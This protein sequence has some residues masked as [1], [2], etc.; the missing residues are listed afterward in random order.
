MISRDD[1]LWFIDQALNGMI[2]IVEDLGDDLAN[3][4]PDIPGANSPYVILAHCLGV[5][6]YWGGHAIA[7]REI[8]RDHQAEFRAKGPVAE[9]VHRTRRTRQQLDQD[10][11]MIDPS[12]PLRLPTNKPEHRE[13]PFGR[14]QGGALVQIETELTQHRGQMEITRDLLGT[15]WVRFAADSN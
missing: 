9:L 10:L 1:S 2:Q 4:R 14:T 6:E 7:G 3:R 8:T 13:L 12:A 5:M 15:A 11:A